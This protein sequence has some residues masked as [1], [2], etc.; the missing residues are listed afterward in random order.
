MAEGKKKDGSGVA[1]TPRAYVKP[2]RPL[3]KK[4]AND[5]KALRG[6]SDSPPSAGPDPRIE[7]P[8][9]SES[10]LDAILARAQ[11]DAVAG[12][13]PDD[14]PRTKKRGKDSADDDT[15]DLAA[16]LI[17]PVLALIVAQFFGERA[18][19]TK[20]ES[21]SAALPL[22]RI[23]ARHLPIGKMSADGLDLLAFLTVGI[24]WYERVKDDIEVP[25]IAT[26]GITKAGPRSNGKHAEDVPAPKDDIEA[27]DP[28]LSAFLGS[29]KGE[30][31]DE[32]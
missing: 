18:K 16:A 3:R 22:G 11:A 30:S 10:P 9:S 26:A 29:V 20:D 28:A 4:V 27:T 24:V 31:P 1:P 23:L 6:A 19:P 14:K 5:P 15:S 2:R 32:E 12:L 8:E 17:A 7:S 25:K 21:E 13:A